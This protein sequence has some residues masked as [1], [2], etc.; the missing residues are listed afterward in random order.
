MESRLFFGVSISA[1][2][3]EDLPKGRLIPEKMRHITLLFLGKC[4]KKKVLSLIS[5]L[6]KWTTSL[7][8]CGIARDLLFF[9]EQNPRVVAC[10]AKWLEGGDS[11]MQF[12]QELE[13]VFVDRGFVQPS[14]RLFI[15]HITIARKPFEMHEWMQRFVPMPFFIRGIEL[16]QSVGNLQYRSLWEESLHPPFEEIPHTADIAFKVYGES[17]AQLHRHAELA[18]AFQFPSFVAYFTSQ[19]Q[20]SLEEIIMALNNAIAMLDEQIGSPWKAVSFHTKLETLNH[21]L[22]WEMI[23]DV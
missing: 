1:P 14:R 23:V 11:L 8:P 2:W 20:N 9:P 15:P 3:L 10:D 12:Q 7:A 16:Y 4:D 17:Y 6:P 5:I 13:R 22:M 19:L 21:L 18:L